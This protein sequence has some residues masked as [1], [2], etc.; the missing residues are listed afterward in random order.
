MGLCSLNL[1]IG[2]PFENPLIFELE[3]NNKISGFFG[4][5]FDNILVYKNQRYFIDLINILN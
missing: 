1:S 5:M 3:N 2:V 4:K